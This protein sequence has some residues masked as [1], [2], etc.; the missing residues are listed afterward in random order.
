MDRQIDDCLQNGMARA[1]GV[2]SE[3]AH[4]CGKQQ[5]EDTRCPS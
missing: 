1:E 4:E 3:Y 5:A 2:E